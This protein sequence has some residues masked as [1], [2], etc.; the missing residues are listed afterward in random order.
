MRQYIK[1]IDR[2]Q[3]LLLPDIVDDYVSES[4]PVRFIEAYVDQLN[5]LELGFQLKNVECKGR[6]AY[7]P[8]DLLKLY[9][10][11]YLNRVRS[12]RRLEHEI[13]VNMELILLVRKLG[14]DLKSKREFLNENKKAV[15]DG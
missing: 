3:S 7:H 4:N 15:H 11:G 9:I 10:Y 2:E 13:C 8:G 6:P 5:L 14:Q 1:G 12:S